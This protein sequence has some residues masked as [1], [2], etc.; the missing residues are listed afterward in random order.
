MPYFFEQLNE[1]TGAG[2]FHAF[3]GG[4][5]A[6][7]AHGR[8]DTG[9]VL[10]AE[11]AAA[12]LRLTD[13]RP[14]SAALAALKRLVKRR[15]IHPIVLGRRQRFAREELARFVR[16]QTERYPLPRKKKCAPADSGL[17]GEGG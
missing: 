13:D 11:E 14:M 7:L 17:T 6:G 1:I 8:V 16:E 3:A 5:A 9:A 15:K 2:A 4:V 12:F 10:S